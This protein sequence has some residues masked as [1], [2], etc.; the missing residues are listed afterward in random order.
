MGQK[1][2][3]LNAALKATAQS[4]DGPEVGAMDFKLRALSVNHLLGFHIKEMHWL[5][6][7]QLHHANV[8]RHH[9]GQTAGIAGCQIHAANADSASRNL[10]ANL[11]GGNADCA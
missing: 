9:A 3:A 2:A 7:L 1:A 8:G 5:H 11:Q 6:V 10:A 4:C